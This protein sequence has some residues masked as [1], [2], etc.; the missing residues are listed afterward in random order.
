MPTYSI[1][2]LP[3]PATWQEFEIICRDLWEKIW[4]DSNTKRNGRQGQSQNGVDIYGRPNKGNKW[5]G[6]QCKG[7]DNYSKNILT[8]EELENEVK[9]AKS[10]E[11]AISEFIVTT[12][13]PKDQ[14]I[15]KLA[16]KITNAHLTNNLFSVD[17]WGWEDIV[18]KLA[19]YSE[20]IRKHYSQF[21]IES[22]PKDI[23]AP[24][25]QAVLDDSRELI[26]KYMPKEALTILEKLK[27]RSWENAKPILKYK[28]YSCIGLAK[29]RMNKSTEAGKLL[30]KAL[31]YN[32]DNENAI[33]NCAL[34]HLLLNQLDEAYI[35]G[36]KLLKMDNLSDNGH[37][38][39]IQSSPTTKS[40]EDVL[41][42]VP[43]ISQK[44]SKVAHALS[45]LAARKNDF[46]NAEKW[47]KIAI[48][49][50][51]E[52]SPY[53][54]GDLGEIIYTIVKEDDKTIYTGQISDFQR[55]KLKDA[56]SYLKEA[57]ETIEHTETREY[58]INWILTISAIK[59]LL[60]DFDGAIKGIEIALEIEPKKALF[61]EN[62]AIL[63]YKNPN[64]DNQEAINI[65][66]EIPDN[67][68]TSQAL[69]LFA[70]LLKNENN[71]N[72]SEQILKELLKKDLSEEDIGRAKK[73]LLDIYI[74]Y[75]RINEANDVFNSL[76][77]PDDR[78]ISNI[79][80]K[81][82]ISKISDDIN[83]T[84]LL[85]KQ[86]MEH[87]TN[88]TSIQHLL[89]LADEFYY[90]G[91]Y[92]EAIII[93]EKS[94]ESSLNTNFTHRLIDS[95]YKSGEIGKAL[96]ICKKL[97]E[98]YNKPLEYVSE[99]EIAIYNEIDDLKETKKLI[100]EYLRIFPNNMDMEIS[101]SFVDL[102][103][104]NLENVDNFLNSNLNLSEITLQQFIE[105]IRLCSYR[106]F[107]E[108]KFLF[109]LYEMRRKYFNEYLAHAEYV[110]NFL[111]KNRAIETPSI[112]EV[113]TAVCIKTQ[114]KNK[115]FVLEDKS[116]VNLNLDEISSNNPLFNEFEGKKVGEEVIINQ[117]SI[118]PQK[119]EIIEIKSKYVYAL[120]ESIDKLTYSPEYLGIDL[121]SLGEDEEEKFEPIFDVLKKKSERNSKLKKIFKE[122]WIPLGTFSEMGSSNILDTWTYVVS[123]PNLGLR[124]YTKSPQEKEAIKLLKHDKKLI[125]DLVSLFTIHEANVKENIIKTFG[126]LGI[127]QSSVDVLNQIL[128]QLM[129]Y[130][131][132][133]YMNSAWIN[134][135]PVFQEVTPQDTERRIK[136]V[137]ELIQWV[138]LNCEILPCHAALNI[139]REHRKKLNEMLG[140][141]FTDTLLIAREPGNLLYSDDCALRRLAKLNYGVDGVWT[142]GVLAECLNRGSIKEE[143]LN[144]AVV[145][146]I[147][148]GY[149][150]TTYNMD[151]LFSAA[152]ESKWMPINPYFTVIN[153]IILENKTPE[154]P[155]VFIPFNEADTLARDEE[156]DKQRVILALILYG[157]INQ[158][159]KQSITKEQR[160]SLT[161][162]L[163]SKIGCRSDGYIVLSYLSSL[164]VD[165]ITNKFNLLK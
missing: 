3:P 150:S 27:H 25:Y 8:E 39:I 113:G 93:Y 165:S 136:Y 154:L 141:S 92:K 91:L 45:H 152:K 42:E 157:F 100:K 103:S 19:E 72:D 82:R 156:K 23:L 95:Y 142:Q 61:K 9:K 33:Y 87:I 108:L 139:N 147:L 120:H 144:N 128:Y 137:E 89:Q 130:R 14:K 40:F 107:N 163:I 60:G 24:E 35:L 101:Q 36:R 149:S 129:T 159:S 138:K 86:A 164:L 62:M 75:N 43:P 10:F 57:W 77:K 66:N 69:M 126:K 32:L 114:N 99:V 71:G 38:I 88:S 4:N 161:N 17:V 53:I 140:K 29:L 81:A 50:N 26:K 7:K 63:L 58:K 79:L 46:K 65:L 28:I 11:P 145:K 83:N 131:G 2:Q 112:V 56:L 80:Y 22:D 74:K 153:T 90:L 135:K 41:S 73:F 18:N 13:G 15:E 64:K 146:L 102:R 158:L 116:N 143:E 133:E 110:W 16:R 21:I 68:K 151:T 51:E 94:V 127:S 115:W 6:V 134:D 44:S 67:K 70:E 52:D 37:F 48:K 5:A 124:C 84:I 59:E 47:L 123:N 97:R 55:N 49:N 31:K 132:R 162:Y 122:K 1:S 78:N 121:F 76:F 119:G 85:L 34:G 30:I 104:N 20:L 125:I 148:F 96:K 98:K 105:L 109:L 111:Y 12:T 155:K 118:S 117:N 54:K 106:D 160:E